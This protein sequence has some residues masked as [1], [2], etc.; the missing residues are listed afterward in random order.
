MEELSSESGEK[1]AASRAGI[2]RDV[3][4]GRGAVRQRPA[5]LR[6]VQ[7]SSSRGSAAGS[8]SSAKSGSDKD[9]GGSQSPGQPEGGVADA[10]EM[11]RQQL[12]EMMQENA[13]DPLLSKT[14]QDA[15]DELNKAE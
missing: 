2:A 10:K 13:T 9:A 6:H 1:G 7:Q 3:R 4:G 5:D 8:R 14:I 11:L 12:R 15:M